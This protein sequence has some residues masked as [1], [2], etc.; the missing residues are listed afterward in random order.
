MPRIGNRPGAF[1]KGRMLKVK[2]IP[3]RKAEGSIC[4]RQT[5]GHSLTS[6]DGRYRFYI[7]EDCP[8][9]D[10]LV[11]QGKGVRHTV[12]YSV[13][14]ENTILLTTEPRSVLIYP[15]SY[16]RQFGTV[17]TCQ[18]KTRH[19]NVVFSPAVLPWFIGYKM[20]SDDNVL[21]CTLDYDKL[22]S[23]PPVPKTKLIS[24][25]TSDK[26]FTQGH[27]DRMRF[28]NVLKN[29]FGD[30]IDVFGRGIN[31]FDDKWDVLAPYKYHVVIEN[32]SQK[33]YW[34]EK[35][36]DCLLAGTFPFYYG[37]TNMSDYIPAGSFMPIDIH[38]PHEAIAAIEKAIGNDLYE[39]SP[40]SLMEARTLMLDKYNMFE[41]IARLCDGMDPTLPKKTVRIR[42]CR[43]GKE[44]H[45]MWRYSIGRKWFELECKL[46]KKTNY[47]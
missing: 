3:Y 32:S 28:V 10:F 14:P 35:M 40:D 34:T 8:D 7:D 18:E 17:C 39:K 46:L 45:N 13:A 42:P 2:L 47:L 31:G 30:R 29:R 41:Y 21:S 38:K 26:S 22:K 24:V 6:L 36:G 12:T 15:K 5:K 25:I 33:Y 4:A 9:P 23:M 37:C 16:I 1:F 44:L 19:K 20:D 43:S 27:I 11:I